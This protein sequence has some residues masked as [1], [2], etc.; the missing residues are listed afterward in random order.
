MHHKILCPHSHTRHALGNQAQCSLASVI[1]STF[2]TQQLFANSKIFL[3]L[4][5][6]EERE[7]ADCLIS[8]LVIT[9]THI[10]RLGINT[11]SLVSQTAAF[12]TK[13]FCLTHV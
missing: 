8:T 7:R 10:S 12:T 11:K 6:Q 4:M 9:K 13:V 1:L 3:H 2:I 5:G